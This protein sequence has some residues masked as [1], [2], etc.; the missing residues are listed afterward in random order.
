MTDGADVL[1]SIFEGRDAHT[2]VLSV[3]HGQ[4]QA[5]RAG[6]DDENASVQ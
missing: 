1:R 3:D 2:F 4:L 5:R 6:V